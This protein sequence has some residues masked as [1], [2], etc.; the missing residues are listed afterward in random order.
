M[1]IIFVCHGNICR[2]PMAEYYF[3][4]IATRAGLADYFQVS[5]AGLS[6]EEE[7][8]PVYPLAKR[9]LASYGIGCKD[10]SARQLTVKEYL[11]ADMVIIMDSKNLQ[12]FQP[13]LGIEP[14]K[15][16]SR[17][18][19]HTLADDAEHHNRDIVDPWYPPRRFDKA[20]EDITI[21][22]RALLEELRPQ[23]EAA[24]SAPK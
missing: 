15:R 13:Y 3:R 4:H 10:K 24:L 5:S 19:D 11:S 23:A 12:G 9:L 7:G 22:C 21:G 2:S 6:N 18:L 1:K 14:D 17:L 16:V 20:W 8:N